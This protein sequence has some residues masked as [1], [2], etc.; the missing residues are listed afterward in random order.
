MDILKLSTDWARAEVFSSKI[1]LLLS[2]LFFLAAFGFW[3]LG[4]T[5]MAKAFIWPMLVAGVLIVAVAA[6]LYFANKPRIAQFETAYTTDAKAFVQAETERTAKSQN[7]FTLVFKVLPLII[8]VAVLLIF[9]VNTPLWR[10]IGITTI[11][12]MTILMF[13]DSNT[14]ARNTVYHQ[15]LI[16]LIK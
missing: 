1:T 11:A 15:Q 3:Q 8:L 2:L 7:D 12:L 4:K 9:F 10:A 14:N 5:S 16:A 6:G 13:I